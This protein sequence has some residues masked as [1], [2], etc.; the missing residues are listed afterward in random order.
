MVVLAG[1]MSRA[2]GR[3]GGLGPDAG[4][5]VPCP[6]GHRWCHPLSSWRWSQSSSRGRRGGGPTG[7][8]IQPGSR[9]RS[10]HGAS[11]QVGRGPEQARDCDRPT[12]AGAGLSAGASA[13]QP[14]GARSGRPGGGAP[15][16]AL[17]TR[18]LPCL[19]QQSCVS[20]QFHFQKPTPG[21]GR[22]ALS[23]FRR[24]GA[25]QHRKQGC[26][27][28]R[29]NS[30]SVVK[31]DLRERLR[32]Q[33]ARLTGENFSLGSWSERTPPGLGCA[34]HSSWA[35]THLAGLLTRLSGAALQAQRWL[36]PTRTSREVGGPGVREGRAHTFAQRRRPRV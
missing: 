2:V 17:G 34:T 35:H 32:R 36:H 27:V 7:S 9:P 28:A 31:V 4:K 29:K 23:V 8:R 5:P 25:T 1:R 30:C 12:V 3:K 16:A 22:E 26:R 19:L 33:Q 21:G 18:N 11:A 24:L 13:R 15:T 20:Q 6:D 14:W 10:V